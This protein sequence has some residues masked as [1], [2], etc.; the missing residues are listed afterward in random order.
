MKL[1]QECGLGFSALYI[2]NDLR[3]VCQPVNQGCMPMPCKL[4][5][6]VS[7][8][9]FMLKESGQRLNTLAASP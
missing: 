4:T 7:K 9:E 2:L 6:N 3:I 5:L 1:V 8:T